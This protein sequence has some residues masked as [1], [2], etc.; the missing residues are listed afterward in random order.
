MPAKGAT[1][2]SAAITPMPS[3]IPGSRRGAA[4]TTATGS[5]MAS[6][7]LAEQSGWLDQED[8]HHDHEDDGVRCFGIEH[9]GQALDH[10]EAE[11]GQDGAE[12][13]AHSADDHHR[14][15]DDD[16]VRAHQR[17]HLV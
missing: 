8:D 5:V 15:N 2:S 7:R 11:T 3:M 12:N 14:E 10:A 6:R 1:A 9:L 4:T 16:Q 17:I 13:R